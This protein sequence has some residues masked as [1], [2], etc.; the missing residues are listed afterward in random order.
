M[1]IAEVYP[2]IIYNLPTFIEKMDQIVV[3]PTQKDLTVM[4]FL[5][6]AWVLLF[7]GTFL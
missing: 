1:I 4:I 3:A 5:G 6:I 7:F 2:M